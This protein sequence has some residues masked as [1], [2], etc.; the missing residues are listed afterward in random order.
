MSKFEKVACEWVGG[1]VD[2]E[3][4]IWF[5]KS[6]QNFLETSPCVVFGMKT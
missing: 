1:W 4:M 3:V 5:A 6:N 2:F